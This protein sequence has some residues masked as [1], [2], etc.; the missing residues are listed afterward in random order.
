M[1]NKKPILY[2]IKLLRKKE[3]YMSKILY[4]VKNGDNIIGTLWEN[5][6]LGKVFVTTGEKIDLLHDL[7][8]RSAETYQDEENIDLRDF[9]LEVMPIK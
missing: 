8:I 2:F 6:K 9:I 5:E 7:Q 1:E 3:K 4:A